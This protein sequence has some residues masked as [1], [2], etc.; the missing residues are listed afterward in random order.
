MYFLEGRTLAITGRLRYRNR[1]G[2]L[3]ARAR[4]QRGPDADPEVRNNAL[5]CRLCHVKYPYAKA[6]EDWP[7][8]SMPI[9][10]IAEQ[11]PQLFAGNPAL[12][13]ADEAAQAGADTIILH[14]FWMRNPGT[15]NEP[16]ADYQ[17]EDPKWLKAFTGRCHRNGMRVLYYI[18]GTE[19]WLQ[20]ATFFEDYLKRDFDGL[21]ADWNTPFFMG[22]VK[23]SPL[24]VSLHNYFHFTRA[25]RQRVGPRGLLI[26]HTNG[27][28]SLTLANFDVALSG[29][30]SVRH[31]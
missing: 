9:K 2:L 14:Q 4:T 15:N 31:D 7:W 21:Y 13:R 10:Q 19:Q 8:V 18:R 12:K 23:C 1:W 29:E 28:N 3:F 20:Y 26:G 22:Y 5:G 30:T 16:P 6:G 17:A 11:P 27:A 24:H 25:L